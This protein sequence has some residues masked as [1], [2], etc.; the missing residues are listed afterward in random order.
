MDQLPSAEVLSPL[1]EQGKLDAVSGS[2]FSG[3]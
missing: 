3:H 1:E 2:Q